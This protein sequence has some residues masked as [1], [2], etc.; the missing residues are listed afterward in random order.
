M[1]N[2]PPTLVTIFSLLR[3]GR[4]GVLTVC[5][6]VTEPLTPIF[7][8][9]LL[10]P[11]RERLKNVRIKKPI[12]SSLSLDGNNSNFLSSKMERLFNQRGKAV[13]CFPGRG[14]EGRRE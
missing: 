1:R 10:F 12:P 2:Q 7:M 8:A 9:A 3:A 5:G 11:S 6:G 4:L 13:W 14:E